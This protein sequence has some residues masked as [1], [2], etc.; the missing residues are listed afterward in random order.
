[1]VTRHTM[2]FLIAWSVVSSAS[3]A[4]RHEG[5]IEPP[6]IQQ[7]TLYRDRAVVVR[8]DAFKVKRGTTIFRFDSLPPNLKEVSLRAQLSDSKTA[9]IAGVTSWLDRRPE[10]QDDKVREA[11]KQVT[12]LARQIE[13]LEADRMVL[14]TSLAYLAAYQKQLRTAISEQ[15]LDPSPKIGDW[16]ETLNVLNKREERQGQELARNSRDL[17]AAQVALLGE[18]RKLKR[19]ENPEPRSVRVV[20]V[21]IEADT[22]ETVALQIL[23]EMDRA[24]WSAIYEI[25]EDADGVVRLTYQAGLQQQTE[26][27]WT[28]VKVTLSTAEPSMGGV[29]PKLSVMYVRARKPTNKDMLRPTAV[30]DTT[31]NRP[32]DIALIDTSA[33]LEM[34]VRHEATSFA[35]ELPNPVTIRRDGRLTK[36]TIA[37]AELP[38]QCAYWVMPDVRMHVYRRL[39]TSNPV[40]FPLLPGEIQTFH[41]GSYV[42]TAQMGFVPVK[43]KF[44]VSTGTDPEII[45]SRHHTTA[46]HRSSGH[47][48]TYSRWTQIRNG[49]T[50]PVKIRVAYT[51]PVSE[52]EEARVTLDKAKFKPAPSEYDEKKGHLFWDFEIP[53]G[54]VSSAAFAYRVQGPKNV[55]RLYKR[56]AKGAGTPFMLD[57]ELR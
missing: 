1:M 27:D 8:G 40:P 39:K 38:G 48:A 41:R 33:S 4:G 19:L 57:L 45:A 24:G 37:T 20:E 44:E 49:K 21:H 42:G 30:V 56:P 7:A 54:G 29:R 43:G 31:R 47:D 53:A 5:L 2:V 13:A 10:I 46:P 32:I 23:Y 36:V 3:G 26:E 17:E 14:E 11:D 55:M 35:F 50:G 12:V 16:S 18:R 22:D 6:P 25:H 34:E 52:V 9:R 51:M 15:T 28:D